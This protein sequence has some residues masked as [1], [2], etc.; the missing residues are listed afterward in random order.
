MRALIIDDEEMARASIK[1]LVQLCCPDILSFAEANSVESGI[2]A[3]AKQ[4]PDILFLDID[5]GDGNG[6]D[7]LRTIKEEDAIQVIFITAHNQYA[8]KALKA[9]AID[10]L[11]KPLKPSELILAFKKVKKQLKQNQLHD[12]LDILLHNLKYEEKGIQKIAIKTVDSIHLININHI[13]YC[14]SDGGYTTFHLINNQKII[15]A[16]LLGEYEAML[17][18]NIFMRIHRSYLVNLNYV[19]RYDKKDK[20]SLITTENHKLPVSTRKRE[21]LITYLDSLS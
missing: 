6:F 8:L 9:S 18:S 16:K 15:N 7:L 1:E 14:Q 20:Q 13:I 5:L 12:Q 11:L 2:I 19:V 4:K 3:I 21:Q 10:Y 17:P